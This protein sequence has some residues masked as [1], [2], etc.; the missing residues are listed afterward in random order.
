[1]KQNVSASAAVAVLVVA[2]AVFYIV[3][4]K[5]A[6]VSPGEVTK[7][8]PFAPEVDP[9]KNADVRKGLRPLG[10]LAVFPPVPPDRNKGVRLAAVIPGSPADRG[11]LKAGDLVTGFNGQQLSNQDTFIYLLSLA[12]PKQSYTVEFVRAGKTRQ[13]SV[14]GVK[15]LPPEELAGFDFPRP[16]EQR[17]GGAGGGGPR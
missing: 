1:V 10:V 2:I 13:V 15:P 14:T 7:P 5:P 17:P 4:N 6:P 16:A 9:S 12:D 11:G 8:L 3:F